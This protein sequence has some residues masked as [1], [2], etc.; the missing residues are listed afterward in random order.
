[1]V[2][3]TPLHSLSFPR[4]A[5]LAFP[6]S[7]IGSSRESAALSICLYYL[8][9]DKTLTNPH[10]TTDVLKKLG[11]VVLLSTTVTFSRSFGIPVSSL[12][13]HRGSEEGDCVM[14]VLWKELNTGI[15]ILF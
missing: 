11:Q 9:G 5:S 4:A 1:M 13:P 15:F 10:H 7:G 8:G 6:A 12:S 2:V 3:H 14:A